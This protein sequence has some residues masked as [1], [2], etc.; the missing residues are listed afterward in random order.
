[1]FNHI[2]LEFT[3]NKCDRKLKVHTLSERR[4]VGWAADDIIT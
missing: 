3:S 4:L 1:M 2:L